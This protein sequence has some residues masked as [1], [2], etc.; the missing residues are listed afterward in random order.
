MPPTYLDGNRYHRLDD[1]QRA[2]YLAGIVDGLVGGYLLDGNTKRGAGLGTCIKSMPN[3]QVRDIV[4]KYISGN[5]EQRDWPMNMLAYNALND[6]C[7]KRGIAI[8]GN[9]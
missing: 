8:H 7:R 9:R 4:D 6:A 1:E 3:D 2:L 5:P